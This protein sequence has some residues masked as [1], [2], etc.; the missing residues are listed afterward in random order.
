MTLGEKLKQARLDAGLSQRQLCGDVITRNM[1]SQIENGSA[2]PSMATL[3]YLASRLE[4]PVSYFL[5]EQA[6]VSPNLAVMEQARNCCRAEDWGGCMAALENYQ[7]PD[8]VCDNE[9][10]LM[11]NISCLKMARQALG[12]GK[13]PY[14]RALL[15]RVAQD[16]IYYSALR[17]QHQFLLAK[18]EVETELVD[19]D[20]ELLLQA[21]AALKKSDYDRCGDL[22]QAV[23]NK[24]NTRWA[25]LK[26]E[27]CF[28]KGDF[29]QAVAWY[30]KAENEFPEKAYPRLEECYRE[31]GDF[32]LAYEYACKQRKNSCQ[33]LSQ[34]V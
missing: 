26:G 10:E 3:S 6:V 5:E 23:K 12:E 2:R 19:L 15:E 21:A 28:G 4:K 8:E 9:A 11:K 20:E 16:S 33:K 27:A 18:A 24:K 30:K 7:A 32:K 34:C 22:L 14:A 31:L 29:A 17:R 13:L 25:L 1:L